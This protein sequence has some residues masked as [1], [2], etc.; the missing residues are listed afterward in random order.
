MRTAEWQAF[1]S[2]ALHITIRDF[3]LEA[4]DALTLDITCVMFVL[5]LLHNHYGDQAARWQKASD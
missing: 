1:F 2:C 4:S 5:F 3:N